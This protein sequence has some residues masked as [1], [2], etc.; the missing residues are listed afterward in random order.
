MNKKPPSLAWRI[1][2]EQILEALRY[3]SGK[4]LKAEQTKLSSAAT[5]LESL[6]SGKLSQFLDLEERETI[7]RAAKLVRDLNL[8]VE[9]AKDVKVR[10]EKRIER[11]RLDYHAATA[12][13]LQKSFP[14]IP[15]DAPDL[16]DRLLDLVELHQGLIQCKHV[17][18][19][20]PGGKSSHFNRELDR[21]QGGQ[22][23]LTFLVNNCISEIKRDLEDFISYRQSR[24]PDPVQALQEFIEAAK[25]ARSVV[26]AKHPDLFE[27]IE[28]L[29]AIEK[30]SNVERLPVQK[31]PGRR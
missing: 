16:P 22:V 2:P 29:I 12:R 31:K 23:T 19:Y 25:D 20:W 24:I 30:S 13:A 3:Y 6:K 21:W 10:E 7:E 17:E 14:F 18:D 27:R 1:T 11:E 28:R 4:Q 5:Q 26:R 9:H 15:K 8:R